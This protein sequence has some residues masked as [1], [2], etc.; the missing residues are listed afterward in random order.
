MKTWQRPMK[1]FK[2]YND[3]EAGAAGTITV[4]VNSK[5]IQLARMK[6][7]TVWQHIDD[8]LAEANTKYTKLHVRLIR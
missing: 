3:N 5:D 8:E 4:H 1:Q 2:P 7:V 6:N